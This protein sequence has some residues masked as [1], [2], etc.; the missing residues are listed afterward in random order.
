MIAPVSFSVFALKSRTD[1][2]V[3]SLADL[4]SLKIGTV[5]GDAV[6][7]YFNKKGFTKLVNSNNTEVAMKMFLLGR[8]D[9]WPVSKQ[10]G[11]YFLKKAGVSPKERLKEVIELKN[12]SAGNQYMAFSLATQDNVV[13]KFKKALRTIKK[14]G[15]YQ[16][17]IEKYEN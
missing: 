4:Q 6:S 13:M 17:I 11:I 2:T 1:I 12:I 15:I 3:N 5:Q 14:K 7:Q 10:T 8:S 16:K 9:V